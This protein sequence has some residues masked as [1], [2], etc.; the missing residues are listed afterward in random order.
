M[1]DIP[2]GKDIALLILRLALGGIFLMHGCQIVLG[3]F[4]GPGLQATIQMFRTDLGIPPVFGYIAAFTQLLGGAALILG[5]MTR[6]AALGIAITMIVA[7]WKVH[8]VHGFFLQNQGYEYNLALI[9]IALVLILRG[10]GDY[11]F[12]KK[13]CKD[14]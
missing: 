4:G 6:L 1:K 8:W 10:A 9:A 14:A 11:A 2:G 12:D 3:L 13:I 7:V 5:L